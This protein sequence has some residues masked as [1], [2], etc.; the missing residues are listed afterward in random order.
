MLSTEIIDQTVLR[1]AF[2]AFPTGVVA[3][4][5][6]VDGSPNVL[7]ASSFAVGVSQTPPMTMFAVQKTSSTW[8]LLRELPSLGVSVLAECHEPTIRQM[9]A[10]DHSQRFAG[11]SHTVL[12]TGAVV[13]DGAPVQFECTIEDIHPAG[14]H[15]IVVLRIL[16]LASDQS[17]QPLVWHRSSCTKLSA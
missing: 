9:S 11:V 13:L 4:A 16:N 10:K 3:L 8:P 5:G 2:A 7:V 15:D 1:G 6:V 12:P 14:D 17:C